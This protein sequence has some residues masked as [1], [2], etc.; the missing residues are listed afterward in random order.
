MKT[1]ARKHYTQVDGD[2]NNTDAV[3][4]QRAAVGKKCLCV[5]NNDQPA[6]ALASTGKEV[7]TIPKDKDNFVGYENVSFIES[8]EGLKE[9][10]F[11]V[12]V[13]G[14]DCHADPINVK[15]EG[16]IFI[17]S[18]KGLIKKEVV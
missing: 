7:W 11:D 17:M 5:S 1:I 10:F 15:L 18:N 16:A 6:L 14:V 3:V 4:L 2:L 9:R 12:L 13:I 8:V